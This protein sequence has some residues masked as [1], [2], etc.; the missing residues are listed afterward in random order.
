MYGIV[1]F[2]FV[3]FLLV[4]VENVYAQYQMIPTYQ[5]APSTPIYKIPVSK[6]PLQ[7]SPVYKD[8][9]ILFDKTSYT[10]P[11]DIGI[12]V[13]DASASGMVTL[14]LIGLSSNGNIVFVDQITARETGDSTGVFQANYF[15]NYSNV[16]W[17]EASSYTFKAVYKTIQK[18]VIFTNDPP[19]SVFAILLLAINSQ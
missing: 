9:E 17:K 3:F 15:Y 19:K 11:D 16:N 14:T 6:V 2:L 18:Y 5:V 7:V 4:V 13:I 12:Q 10:I 1:V 8:P